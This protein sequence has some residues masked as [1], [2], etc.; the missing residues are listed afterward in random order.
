M[1]NRHFVL[2]IAASKPRKPLDAFIKFRFVAPHKSN[3]KPRDH[4]ARQAQDK[5][6]L[7]RIRESG[8]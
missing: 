7:T 6:L 8:W 2:K 5:D 3:A 4:V 1:K